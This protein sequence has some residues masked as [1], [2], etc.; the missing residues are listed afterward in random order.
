MLTLAACQE[1][2]D[3]LFGPPPVLPPHVA[4]AWKAQDSPWK[5][6]LASDGTV[7]SFIL[8]M[9]NVLVKPNSTTKVEMLDGS[10]STFTAGDCIVEYDPDT[11]ELF[12]DIQM[13]RIHVVFMDNV[14]DGNSV[15][16]FAG[17]V[18]EDGK[19]WYADF[20]EIFDYGPRF[21]QDPNEIFAVP[22]TFE[23]VKE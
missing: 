13:E 5:I 23:K 9:G 7:S 1:P 20:T 19:N 17:P 2:L 10:F 11:R 3:G 16:V 12:V 6:V 18:S 22:L 14:I 15:N 4:G 21:P 8:P